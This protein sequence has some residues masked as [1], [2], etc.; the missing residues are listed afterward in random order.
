MAAPKLLGSFSDW[1][2]DAKKQDFLAIPIPVPDPELAISSWVWPGKED[3]AQGAHKEPA[4]G[5]EG[6][7]VMEKLEDMD[8]RLQDVT[9]KLE[10]AEIELEA[11]RKKSARSWRLSC[12]LICCTAIVIE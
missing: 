3:I 11:L 12:R 1:L 6:V 10:T 7:N 9:A 4:L 2:P 8:G 5:V